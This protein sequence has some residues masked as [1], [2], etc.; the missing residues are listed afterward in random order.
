MVEIL[1]ATTPTFQ[2]T[3]PSFVDLSSVRN[4]CFSLEQNKVT[5]INKYSDSL[6]IDGRVVSVFLTQIETM[7]L[8]GGQ[9]TIMLNW[10]YEDGSRGGTYPVTITVIENLLKEVMT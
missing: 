4:L 7:Q 3:V 6:T 10:L 8:V 2:I 1:Q 9:A 5:K